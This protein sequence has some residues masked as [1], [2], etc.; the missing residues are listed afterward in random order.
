M[1]I[2]TPN[3][4]TL[5]IVPVH[6][7]SKHLICFLIRLKLRLKTACGGKAVF[8]WKSKV[9]KKGPQNVVAIAIVILMNNLFIKKYWNAPLRHR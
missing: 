5:F 2:M 1:V 6:N 7:I 4:I 3:N 9:M 8:L